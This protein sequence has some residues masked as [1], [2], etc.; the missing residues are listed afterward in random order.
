M[1]D[2]ENKPCFLGMW[3]AFLVNSIGYRESRINTKDTVEN[4]LPELSLYAEVI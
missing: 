2:C 1:G 3:L 4:N